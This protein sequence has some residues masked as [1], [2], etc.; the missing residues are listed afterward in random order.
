M[1]AGLLWSCAAMTISMS[2]HS[3]NCPTSLLH[4]ITKWRWTHRLVSHRAATSRTS[5]NLC[6]RHTTST[7]WADVLR[8]C[9]TI[10]GSCLVSPAIYSIQPQESTQGRSSVS[11]CAS[12]PECSFRF[13]NFETLKKKRFRFVEEAS[14]IAASWYFGI[15]VISAYF[16]LWW[17]AC[18]KSEKCHGVMQKH[19]NVMRSVMYCNDMGRSTVMV[20]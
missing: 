10:V 14:T 7:P 5:V 6:T 19:S 8:A 11:N 9:P 2:S 18:W 15:F 12:K 17:V 3:H 4:G 20:P 13:W 1:W 16:M